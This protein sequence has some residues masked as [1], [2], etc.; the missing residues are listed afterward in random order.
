M[1]A[2]QLNVAADKAALL[3]MAMPVFGLTTAHCRD[4]RFACGLF[5][6]AMAVAHVVL[7]VNGVYPGAIVLAPFTPHGCVGKGRGRTGETLDCC[8]PFQ[9]FASSVRLVG[10]SG[11]PSHADV[12]LLVSGSGRSTRTPH[13]PDA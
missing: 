7:P 4:G 10:R 12:A 8:F 6:R 1:Q 11:V 3:Q 9:A 2:G 5:W 13:L